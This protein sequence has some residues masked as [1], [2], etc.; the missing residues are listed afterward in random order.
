MR[1][2]K[3]NYQFN[4]VYK[5]YKSRYLFPYYNFKKN[6]ETFFKI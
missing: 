3:V 6:V 5:M 1:K 4:I 2:K